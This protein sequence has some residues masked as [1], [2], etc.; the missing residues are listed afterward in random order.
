MLFM[1]TQFNQVKD[2]IIDLWEQEKFNINPRRGEIANL[3]SCVR[4]AEY[5]D[6]TQEQ[7]NELR[8]RVDELI[9]NPLYAGRHA[10]SQ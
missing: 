7:I 5:T 4:M 2:K 9:N 8:D 1:E 3:F 10:T 6:F